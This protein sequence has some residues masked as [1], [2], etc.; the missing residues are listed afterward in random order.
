VSRSPLRGAVLAT[1]AVVALAGLPMPAAGAQPAPE[2]CVA[3]ARAGVGTDCAT[4][5]GWGRQVCAE[6]DRGAT[7][8]AVAAALDVRTG[9]EMLSNFV[10]AGAPM[11]LCPQHRDKNP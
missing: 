1:G 9:D 6:Y 7:W 8:D 11:Y 5:L 2:F 10:I 4:L 3:M